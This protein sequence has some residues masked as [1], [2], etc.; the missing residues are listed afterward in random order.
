M[1]K[2]SKKIRGE[3]IIVLFEILLAVSIAIT[4]SYFIHESAVSLVNSDLNNDVNDESK[5]AE[6]AIVLGFFGKIIFGE[7]GIVSALESSDLQNGAYTCLKTKNNSICQEFPASECNS[8]CQANCVPTG[9]NLVSQCLIGTCYDK[10]EGTCS[11]G[12]P[13]QACEDHSG[14]WFSDQYGNIQECKKGCCI[15]GEN[16]NF[17]TEQQCA[18]SAAGLGIVK[19][20]KPETNNELSC[21]QQ[22]KTQEQGACV[23]ESEFENT[24]KFTTKAN[25]L[26]LG[27]GFYSGYLCS[28]AE[29]QTNCKPQ[30]TTSCIN[31]KDEVYWFDSCGNRENIYDANKVKSFNNGKVLSKNESCSLGTSSNAFSNKNICG[32]CNYLLGSTCGLKESG[33]SI[34]GNSICKDLRCKDENGAVR[35]NGESWCAYQGAI[36]IDKGVGTTKD[37]QPL[38]RSIDVVGSRNFRKVCIDGEVR[39][40]PCADYRNEICVQ[41][42]TKA[43]SKTFSSAACRI[44]RWQQC[45]EY[46]T[47]IQTDNNPNGITIEQRNTK[48]TENSDCFIKSVNLGKGF[49]FGM[50]A[51]KYPEGFD[52][53]DTNSGSGAEAICSFASQKCTE[54]WV[55]DVGGSWECVANCQ[56][57][58]TKF[59]EQMNDLCISLGD[60]G[61][62]ANVRGE[63][64]YNS[65]VFRSNNVK[66]LGKD[67]TLKGKGWFPADYVSALKKYS[68]YE[69]SPNKFAAPGNLS[70]FYGSLGIPEGLGSAQT[71]TD[72]A[73]ALGSIGM[74]AGMTG[75]LLVALS[76]TGV[77]LGAGAAAFFA[78][79]A[80]VTGAHVG[81]AAVGAAVAANPG[82]VAAG[83]ALAGAAIG[84]A[85]VSML[86]QFTGIGGAIGEE[87][88]YALMAAGAVAGAI[89][90]AN[91]AAGTSALAG[92]GPLGAFAAAALT[93]AI[94][95]IIAVV[96]FIII[97][98]ILGAGDIKKVTYT[99]Q[100]QPWQAP[101]G[102]KDCNKCGKNELP[103]GKY[104]CQSLGQTCQF[105]NEGTGQEACVDVSPNDVSSPIINPLQSVLT[106]GFSYNDVSDSGFKIKSNEND[107]CLKSYQTLI[108]GIGTNEASYCKFE[109]NHTASFEEMES[110]LGGSNLFLINH[111]QIVQIPSLDSLG[112]P[113]YDP[114]RKADYSLYLRCQDKS[115]NANVNEYVVNFCIKP[116]NDLTPPVVTGQE[117]T[118]NWLKYNST[119]IKASV[120]TN[121]PSDCKWDKLDTGYEQMQNNMTCK[122]G[123]DEQELLGWR[124]SSTFPITANDNSFYVKCKDQPWLMDT[125]SG[126]QII[127][128]DKINASELDNV[129]QDILNAINNPATINTTGKQRNAMS[130]SYLLSFKRTQSQLNIDYLKPDNQTIVSGVEPVSVKVEVKTSGGVDG[131]SDCQYQIRSERYLPLTGD[132]FVPPRVSEHSII[133]QLFNGEHWLYAKCWDNAGNIAEKTTRFGVEIDTTMPIVTRVYNSNGLNVI[134][135]ENAE[136]TYSPSN[137]E[138]SFENATLMDGSELIHTTRFNAN[139][140]YYVK[141]KDKYGNAPG[142]CSIV[143][144]GVDLKPEIQGSGV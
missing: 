79:A 116:G 47:Q 39:I 64:T 28:T 18:A 127:V 15:R 19:N 8:N 45:L 140:I 102:G 2:K 143:V 27:G 117:P 41:A 54:V 40:D 7:K 125:P 66:K 128:D 141:C 91:I 101:L 85:V 37:K 44:N 100:C 75:I 124:C 137:C 68:D 74:I 97:E 38:F 73:A 9:R 17:V 36:G 121:E 111:T 26:T 122:N 22:S 71:P 126:Q 106:Q 5:I 138:F 48:C 33:D 49:S 70:A 83:G 60:C 69:N 3:K 120:F 52:L 88:A 55:K 65:K 21:I 34:Y 6:L 103:C 94:V 139:S 42:D 130:T 129:D 119:D 98:A 123:L 29:L 25:C 51:P 72:P 84:F 23:F 132:T 114:E 10:D 115:G 14:Q 82:M 89:I 135:D 76:Y 61:T 104:E 63:V 57:H 46:N 99:F 77:A 53:S 96:V 109:A 93:F 30:A 131:K 142:G 90:G 31:E 95:I 105:I 43:G 113:G 58:T 133:L 16:A 144:K 136:C 80:S 20:F 13:K 87:G 62:K 92:M 67:V 108:F 78:G 4:T 110:D 35:Q 12:S 24:C 112:I 86:I 107:G 118:Y 134:T 11:T 50:C 56:C 81:S 32:N 59:S 1:K